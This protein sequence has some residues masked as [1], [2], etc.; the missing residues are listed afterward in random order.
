LARKILMRSHIIHSFDPFLSFPGLFSGLTLPIWEVSRATAHAAL[1]TH[2]IS[3]VFPCWGG[4]RDDS[5][6]GPEAKACEALLGEA[7]KRK[8][9]TA[10]EG[11]GFTKGRLGGKRYMVSQRKPGESAPAGNNLLFTEPG[12][13]QSRRA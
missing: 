12:R 3:L 5:L 11:Q 9:R 1:R 8:A 6:K 13:C 10:L 4:G 2:I 7:Q